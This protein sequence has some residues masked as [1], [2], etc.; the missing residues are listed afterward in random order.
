MA[1]RTQEVKLVSFLNI[2][3]TGSQTTAGPQIKL[4]LFTY[5]RSLWVLLNF[6]THYEISKLN[7]TSC[8]KK[9][10]NKSST[11]GDCNTSTSKQSILMACF[12]NYIWQLQSMTAVQG[13]SHTD[14]E[15]GWWP[16]D[17]NRLLV[18]KYSPFIHPAGVKLWK[19]WIE[20]YT[21]SDGCASPTHCQE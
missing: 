15:T 14:Q 17:N 12:R 1:H 9:I 19:I 6:N 11:A 2:S 16:L 8:L 3:E 5:C 7:S 18:H 4:R 13:F 10:I 21:L 20:E